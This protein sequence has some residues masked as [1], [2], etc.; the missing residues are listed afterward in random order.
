MI[1]IKKLFLLLCIVLVSLNAGCVTFGT[2]TDTKNDDFNIPQDPNITIRFVFPGTS[3]PEIEVAEQ[4]RQKMKLKFPDVEIE[5]ILH[6]WVDLEDKLMELVQNGTIPDILITQDVTN[7]V[8]KGLLSDLTPYL[9]KNNNNL[10]ED[11]FLPGTLSYSIINDKLY[12]IPLLA[13]SFCLIVNE[14]MLNNVGMEIEDLQTWDDLEQAAKLMTKEGKYGFG[15]PLAN[16]RYA[17]RVPLTAA[18][19]NGF[20]LDDTSEQNRERYIQTLNHFLRLEPYQPRSHLQWG[21]PEMYRAFSLE[22]VGIIAAGTF[23]SAVA[24]SVNPD[25]MKVSRA[26][27]YPMGPSAQ[28]PQAPVSNA[29]ISMFNE[30]RHKDI[31]WKLIEEW[32]SP[33]F[34]SSFVAAINV[35]ALKQTSFDEVVKKAEKYYPHAIEGHKVI[36]NDMNR[37]I[38]SYGVPMTRITGQNEMEVMVQEQIVK[39]LIGKQTAEETYETIREKNLEIKSKYKSSSK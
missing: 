3:E 21:Y 4:F 7:L 15:Y 12:S 35:A 26:I 37:L 8:Y 31:V 36:L 11:D 27:V 2:N 13:N 5:Y 38:S 1:L 6:S 29:G 19:S 22:E 17:F 25:I 10:H 34:N 28:K 23:F 9:K 33:E 18:Y 30:S 20:L 16:P 24:Y 14:S 39:M 32:A